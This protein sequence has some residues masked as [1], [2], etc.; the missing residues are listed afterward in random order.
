VIVNTMFALAYISEI[1]T[2]YF[3][4]EAFYCSL[5]LHTAGVVSFLDN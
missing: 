4:Y 1:P 3:A 5:V 2:K